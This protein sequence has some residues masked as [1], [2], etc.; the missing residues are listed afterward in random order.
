[1]SSFS[2]MNISSLTKISDDLLID[3]EIYKSLKCD[4]NYN[5]GIVNKKNLQIP[6]RNA[7]LF[8]FF[9]FFIFNLRIL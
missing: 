1:M 6:L 7:Y 9:F 8:I 5:N 3:K 4:D 2:V